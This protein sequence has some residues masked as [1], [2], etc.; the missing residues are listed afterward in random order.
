MKF[1]LI[2]LFQ[3][4]W[5]K[6]LEAVFDNTN[7]TIDTKMDRVIVMDLK[8]LQ[9]LPKLLTVT[10]FATIGIYQLF[11]CKILDINDYILSHIDQLY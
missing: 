7:V 8:Y 5:T 9:E 1:F 2:D 11:Y 3:W 4:N 6:Y 10:P